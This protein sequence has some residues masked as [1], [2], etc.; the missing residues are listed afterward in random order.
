MLC[1]T[2]CWLPMSS[3]I[4]LS[5][6]LTQETPL[7]GTEKSLFNVQQVKS[8]LK[9]D[10]C[11]KFIFTLGSHYG[12]HIDFPNHFFDVPQKIVD[13]PADFWIFNSPY[14]LH[15]EVL[16]NQIL[17]RSD[18]PKLPKPC[19][20]L[21]LKTQFQSHRGSSV[22]SNNNPGIHAEVGQWLRQEY[23]SLRAIGFDFISLSSYQ[24]PEVGRQAHKSFLDP[25]GDHRSILIIEDMDLSCDLSQLKQLWISPLRMD[26]IDSAP[27]TILGRCG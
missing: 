6:P 3:Y 19:D 26:D 23:P 12:T 20:I 25:N 2:G 10:S 8:L 16:P 24:N 4:Y 22:Y 5:H 27:C 14:V 13:Y 11:N 1:I 15:L 21:L 9:G 7:Y 18:F 17:R